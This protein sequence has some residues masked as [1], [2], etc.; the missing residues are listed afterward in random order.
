MDV[1]I[2]PSEVSGSIKA[3]ASKSFAH[4]ALICAALSESDS[5]IFLNSTSKDIE[6]T[7]ECLMSL[8]AKITR[9]GEAMRVEPVKEIKDEP[10]FCNE[11]GSTLRFLLPVAAAIKDKSVFT[12]AGKLPERPLSP[13]KE[14][15]ERH[16]VS[17]SNGFPLEINGSLS[18]GEYVLKGNVS[19]QFVSGLLFALPLLDGDSEIKLIPP[20]ESKPYIDMT[21][22]VLRQFGIEITEGI[23]SYFV[24][25]NQ[26]YRACDYTVEGDWSNSAYFLA[27]GVK[28]AGLD[29]SSTQGDRAFLDIMNSFGASVDYKGGFI[30]LKNGELHGIT[31][32][33]KNIPDLVPLLATV[34]A[35]AKGQTE[36]YNAGRLRFKE[37]DR[38]RSTY[39]MLKNLGADIVSTDDGFIINGKDRLSGGEVDSFNDHRIVMSASVASLKCENEVKIKNAFAVAKSYPEFFEHFNLLGGNAQCL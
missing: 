9:Q 35:T 31:I 15:M 23:N 2:T 33:A 13:L 22:E 20:V 32:D 39:E 11:S 25:G 7:A 4:R 29:M 24:K 18:S 5:F 21:V 8:G 28:V 1:R 16:G 17:F 3:I 12:A 27:M 34:A 26:V 37:S 38:L 36:I 19:S 14:E 10:L 30:S 6:A